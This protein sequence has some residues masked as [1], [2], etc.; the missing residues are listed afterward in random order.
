[1]WMHAVDPRSGARTLSRHEV[2]HLGPIQLEML[3][4]LLLR[5]WGLVHE[6]RP[7]LW[8]SSRPGCAGHG[9]SWIEG[10]SFGSTNNGV[11]LLWTQAKLII[12]RWHKLIVSWVGFLMW[13]LAAW[14]KGSAIV[15]CNCTGLKWDKNHTLYISVWP[16]WMLIR[17]S[18]GKGCR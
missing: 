8:D 15:T 5:P 3:P 13:S 17:Q 11:L 1:M 14:M 6:N 9:Y 18:K 12:W 16:T 4:W 7:L 2:A 10:V